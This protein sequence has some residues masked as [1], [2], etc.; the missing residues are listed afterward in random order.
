MT[1]PGTW[2]RSVA[3]RV[4]APAT[5]ERVIDPAIADVQAEH[6]EA[7]RSGSVWRPAWVRITGFITLCRTGSV[8]M[9]RAS[10]RRTWE[11]II[12]DEHSIGRLLGYSSLVIALLTLALALIPLYGT[13]RWR[14]SDAVT[15]T[16]YLYV[17]PQA[18]PLAVVFGLPVGILIAMHGRP[19]TSRV[20]RGVVAI[21]ILS[22][23]ATFVVAAW[24]LPEAN[25]AFRELASGRPFVVRGANE[26][27]FAELSARLTALERRGA[28]SEA[29]AY[30]M[31]YHVRLAAS[32]A[33]I[34]M[35]AFALALATARRRTAVS[36]AVIAIALIVYVGYGG[37]V[38]AG[39]RPRVG[40]A[41]PLVGL[42]WLP[43]VL[44]GFLAAL[45]FVRSSASA[46]R[47]SL[48]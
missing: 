19:V 6:A 44:F 15:A 28:L 41:L 33:P 22:A 30:E 35:S 25:Q 29:F 21:G 42:V 9:A 11:W 38:L 45:L 47:R 3:R 37:A 5:L 12:A 24:I 20:C 43:N 23:I 1:R 32:F 18:I 31:S 46:R 8:L 40:S 17:I 7:V 36:I 48:R 13:Q 16:L 34:V 2:F 10:T 14:G 4:C 26:L 39:G 27:T